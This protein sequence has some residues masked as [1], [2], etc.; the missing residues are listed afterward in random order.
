LRGRAA[1]TSGPRRPDGLAYCSIPGRVY[2]ICGSGSG[3]TRSEKVGADRHPERHPARGR[4]HGPKRSISVRS[5]EVE[6]PACAGPLGRVPLVYSPQAR[7]RRATCAANGTCAVLVLDRHQHRCATIKTQISGL[8]LAGLMARLAQ[9][10]GRGNKTPGEARP[11]RNVSQ[12]DL[13]CRDSADGIWRTINRPGPKTARWSEA[14]LLNRNSGWA[15]ASDDLAEKDPRR[16]PRAVQ[17]KPAPARFESRLPAT[18]DGSYRWCHGRGAGP[19]PHL[20]GGRV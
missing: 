6:F 19:R 2:G 8:K 17:G 14:E 1:S 12:G 10:G 5:L 7:C 3:R 15:A 4:R 9:R 18:R 13:L 16:R 20:C 11:Y